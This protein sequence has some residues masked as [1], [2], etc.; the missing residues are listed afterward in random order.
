MLHATPG[1]YQGHIVAA[2]A[3]TADSNNIEFDAEVAVLVTLSHPSILSLYGISKDRDGTPYMIM[4]YCG[5][6]DLAA[7]IGKPK[8]GNTEFCRIILELLSGISYLHER[9]VAHRD[10][11]VGHQRPLST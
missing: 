8:F 11:K 1:K 4:D 3:T 10:L 5:G 7:Y 9:G 2:K 6:G